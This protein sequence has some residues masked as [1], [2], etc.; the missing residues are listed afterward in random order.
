M[1]RQK[2]KWETIRNPYHKLENIKR[3]RV[4]RVSGKR[5]SL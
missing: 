4:T 5:T 3:D 1:T 2:M